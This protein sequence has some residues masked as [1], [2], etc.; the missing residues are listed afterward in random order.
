[1]RRTL[2]LLA[3]AVLA[4]AWLV[5]DLIRRPS[6]E[7]DRGVEGIEFIV[8]AGYTLVTLGETNR[9][10]AAGR[11]L[12]ALDTESKLA[13]RFTDAGDRI[14]ILVDGADDTL[15][16]QVMGRHGTASSVLWREGVRERLQWARTHG[17]FDAPGLPE[18]V[19]RNPY[20]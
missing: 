13:V 6:P 19:R 11:M 3:V 12:S 5:Q 1:M 14:Q 18:P 4:G 10:G 2:V 17:S 9:E 7:P 16:E 15:D 8:P 20:H